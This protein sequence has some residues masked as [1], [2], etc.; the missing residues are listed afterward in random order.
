MSKTINPYSHV[1]RQA[2]SLLKREMMFQ[3]KEREKLSWMLMVEFLGAKIMLGK[4]GANTLFYT[5][6]NGDRQIGFP[7]VIIDYFDKLGRQPFALY[8]VTYGDK[9][10]GFYDKDHALAI[11]PKTGM[12][13]VGTKHNGE[14]QPAYVA[15]KNLAGKTKWMPL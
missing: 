3:P 10:R 6:G 12:R 4:G 15:K 7:N 13:I 2:R 5:L 11:K 1:A 14:K 8:T 9:R